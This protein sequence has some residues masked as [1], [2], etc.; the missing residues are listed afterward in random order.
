M[1][2]V[3]RALRGF[4]LLIVL[5][6]TSCNSNIFVDKTD[7]PEK[8]EI[9][10][11]GNGDEWKSAISV[12][13]LS[14]YYVNFSLAE[15][16]YVRYYSILGPETGPDAPANELAGIV[17]ENPAEYYSISIFGEMLNIRVDYNCYQKPTNIVLYLEYEYGITKQIS[18]LI[19]PGSPL[20]SIAYYE[21]NYRLNEKFDKREQR[22]T[23]FT[24]G[25]EITQKIIIYPFEYFKDYSYLVTPENS[26]A[27]DLAIEIEIPFFNG[28][29]WVLQ[30]NESIIMGDRGSLSLPDLQRDSFTIE[31]PPLKKVTVNLSMYY[32][33]LN[34]GGKISFTNPINLFSVEETFETQVI[35]PTSFD[36]SVE[37]E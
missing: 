9:I 2:S 30:S 28:E 12:K 27:D 35:C 6:I 17:Y 13:G 3:A 24:N 32:T 5:F 14:R 4:I 22:I 8:L 36:Y 1:N 10:L 15:Q 23:S 33:E 25:S 16:E 31:V 19:T 37:Y 26:W 7:I 29:E 20:L 21:G 34:W 18:I 11:D